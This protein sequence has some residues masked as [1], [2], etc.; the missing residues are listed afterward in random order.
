M[1]EPMFRFYMPACTASEAYPGETPGR[2]VAEDVWPSPRVTPSVFYLNS[3][4]L[5]STPEKPR[6]IDYAANKVVGLQRMEWV[7][8]VMSTDLAKEQSPDDSYSVVF[9]S[10]P[11]AADLEI[12]GQP[13][14]QLRVGADVPV[15]KVAVRLT[16]VTAGGKSW[17]VSYGLLNLT[18]R[19]SHSQPVALIPGQ[20]YDVELP[21]NLTAHCFKKNNR[22]RI[23][24]SESLWPSV[25][26]SPQPVTL[27]LMTG[28]SSLALPV[29]PP[30]QPEPSFTIPLLH[31]AAG[32]Q[33]GA[34]TVV[35]SGPDA[36]GRVVIDR[37]WPDV[38]T[39][40]EKTQTTI[41][42]GWRRW[43]MEVTAGHP[44]SGHW[45]GEF[46]Q[47]YERADWGVNVLLARYELTSTAEEFQLHESLR[48][49]HDGV[50][51]G[52]R[53]WDHTIKR[54]LM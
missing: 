38:P 43:H 33:G 12:I 22:I 51:L 11:L 2:W 30:R 39:L 16:E 18:H 20:T 1:A 37:E 31:L 42:S 8:F 26:P 5:A 44:N 40:I 9:D 32:S 47:R 48:A 19:V 25:W 45:R 50:V 29:R 54:D 3:G 23:A 7:P 6:K 28:A 21:L 13:I 41:S 53:Q 36:T 46:L 10:A 35:V 4:E 27:M 34:G 14:A 52:E 15:A 17:L 49:T 24:V